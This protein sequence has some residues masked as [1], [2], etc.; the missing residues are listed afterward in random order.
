MFGKVDRDVFHIDFSAP[1]S[2]LQ[3]FAIALSSLDR[4]R[5]VT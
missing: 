3:A 5:L 1:I 2:P 4:K